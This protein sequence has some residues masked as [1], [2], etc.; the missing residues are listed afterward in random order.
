MFFTVFTSQ[1]NLTY[2]ELD[3]LHRSVTQEGMARTISYNPTDVRRRLLSKFWETGFAET[4]LSDLETAT[5]LNRRQLYNGPG[6]KKAMFLTAFDDFSTSAGRQFLAPLEKDT[7]G[8]DEIANLLRCFVAL[9]G[10]REGPSGCMVCSVS[11]EAIAS[12][13]DVRPRIDAYFN[14]IEAAYGNALTQASA[15]GEVSLVPPEIN[16]KS[17][18]L[19]GVHVALCVLGRGGCPQEKLSR[20]AEEAISSLT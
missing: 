15:R 11:Q 17:V 3:I 5:G 6:D 16:A 13:A 8:L 2:G 12:D 20:M 18:M 10:S 19:F 14:R 4:S 1:N 7:A 9:A